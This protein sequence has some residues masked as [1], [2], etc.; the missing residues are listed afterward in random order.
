MP[1]RLIFWMPP[2]RVPLTPPEERFLRRQ[3]TLAVEL[4]RQ[5]CRAIRCA[6]R[7]SVV[8]IF[9]GI[10]IYVVCPRDFGYS[11]VSSRI[12]ARASRADSLRK[13]GRLRAPVVSVSTDAVQKL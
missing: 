1:L 8:E 2:L 6:V 5:V 3:T 11:D 9:A 12:F 7:Q 4:R 10:R 13:N